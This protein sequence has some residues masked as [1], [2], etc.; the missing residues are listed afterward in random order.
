M[1][2]QESDTGCPAVAGLGLA[3]T[4]T[5]KGRDTTEVFWKATEVA[6]NEFMIS[7]R[8]RKG[9]IRVV[10]RRIFRT[11]LLSRKMLVLD[12]LWGRRS[13]RKRR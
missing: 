6:P 9:E 5:V 12:L 1:T 7:T 11:T 10:D 2:V 13:Q 4:W 8:K 3:M